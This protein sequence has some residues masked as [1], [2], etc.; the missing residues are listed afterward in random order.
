MVTNILHLIYVIQA[1]N[2]SVKCIKSQKLLGNDRF[3]NELLK[4]YHVYNTVLNKRKII[5]NQKRGNWHVINCMSNS[6]FNGL[7][8]KVYFISFFIEAGQ[9]V[10]IYCVSKLKQSELHLFTNTV[11]ERDLCEWNKTG[12][13]PI[14]NLIQ[15]SIEKYFFKDLAK[16]IKS[17]KEDF[18]ALYLRKDERLCSF[19]RSV[20]LFHSSF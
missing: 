11:I 16:F 2:F 9:M 12:Y 1:I 19:K 13:M 6:F 18:S 5:L 20:I 4:I 14:F 15:S 8:R 10:D 7:T 3:W 17:T